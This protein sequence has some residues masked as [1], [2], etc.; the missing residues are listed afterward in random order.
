MYG[1]CKVLC[2]REV[3]GTKMESATIL[4]PCVIAGVNDSTWRFSYW[5]DRAGRGGV[6]AAP[7]PVDAPVAVV[8]ARDVATFALHCVEE[9]IDETFVLAPKPYESTMVAIVAAAR[10]AHPH[11][12]SDVAWLPESYLAENN[13][14]PWKGLPLWLPQ[15]TGKTGYNAFDAR[16]AY[17]AGFETRSLLDTATAV[18]EWLESDGV[19]LPDRG[20][21]IP[22]EDEKRLVD[23]W[24][25]QVRR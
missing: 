6:I 2:E 21:T 16:K 4:R 24:L 15:S 8:D 23:A 9:A 17:A 14:V 3:R 20:A 1:E 22:L 13:V 7:E 5:V 19:T 25:E 10:A 12:D 18:R 11:V